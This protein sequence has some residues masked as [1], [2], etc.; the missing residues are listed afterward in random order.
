MVKLTVDFIAKGTSGYAKKKKDETIT[1]YVGRLTHLYLENKNIDDIGD[2][3]ASCRNLAVLYLYDNQLNRIP[4]LNSN[5]GIT[6]LYLQNN[7][8]SIIENLS[9]LPQLQKLYIGGN[10]IRVMEGL[11]NLQKLQE[12]HIEHQ[13]L[14][15]GEQLLFDPRSLKAL[16]SSLQVLNVSGNH[17]TSIDD[18]RQLPHLTHLMAADNEL[19]DMKELG[20]LLSIWHALVRLDLAGNPLCQSP[21]YKDRIIVKGKNLD[22]L[23]GKKITDTARQ[24]LMNWQASRDESRR[25]QHDNMMR[26]DTFLSTTVGYEGAE[27]PPLRS[28]TKGLRNINGYVMP[29]IPRKQFDDILA[30]SNFPDRERSRNDILRAKFGDGRILRMEIPGSAPISRIPRPLSVERMRLTHSA[31]RRRL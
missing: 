13:H 26:D 1:Q 31:Q 6:H 25:R 24:F 21:K 14:P 17:L 4:C 28:A 23:D 27:L 7:K 30:K 19:T 12:L 5:C 16:E 10:F 22:V 2:G 9:T 29:G 20:Q 11:E 3:L 8:I 15:L 18:L